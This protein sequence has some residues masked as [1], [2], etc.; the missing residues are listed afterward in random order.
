MLRTALAGPDQQAILDTVPM[1][2]AEQKRIT[3]T[4]RRRDSTMATLNPLSRRVTRLAKSLK[5]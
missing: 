2:F 1:Q 4:K 5:V 3:G